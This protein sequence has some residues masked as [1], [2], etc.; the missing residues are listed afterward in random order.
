MQADSRRELDGGIHRLLADFG[1]VGKVT[2][3]APAAEADS[4]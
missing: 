2:G 4:E 3:A 1:V